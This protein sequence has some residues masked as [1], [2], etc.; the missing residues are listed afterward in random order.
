M[1]SEDEMVQVR[2]LLA[3]LTRLMADKL[4]EAAVALLFSKRLTQPIQRVHPGYEYLG[5]DDPT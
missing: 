3:E 1:P 5:H 4:T 2:I